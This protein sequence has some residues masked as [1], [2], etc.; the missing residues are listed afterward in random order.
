[1]SLI[2]ITIGEY[3]FIGKLETEKAPNTVKYF[4]NLLPFKKKVIHVKWS[5]EAFWIP[6]GENLGLDFENHTSHL[7]PGEIIIYPG[8]YSEA[9]LLIP[10]GATDF[11][12]K[13]GQLAGNHFITIIEGNENLKT[14]GEKI[15]WEGAQSIN[16]EIINT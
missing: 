2:K 12:S 13:V 11:S 6:L 9:E 14:I 16:F 5:G 4:L 7:S 1:M 8:G 3:E 15:L 10:Y